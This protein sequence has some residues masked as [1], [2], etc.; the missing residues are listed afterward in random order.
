MDERDGLHVDPAELEGS[1]A[2][3]LI[4]ALVVPR[5]IAWVST[6]SADGVANLAPFSYYAVLS[7]R[8]PTVC[9]SCTGERDTLRN[10]RHTGDF[11]ANVVPESLAHQMNLTAADFPP[12]ESEFAAAGLTPLQSDV[13]KAPRLLESPASLECVV[14]REFAVGAG[15]VV[16]VGRVV[17]IHVVGEVI[18]DGR[19]DVSAFRPVGR[20]AGSGYVYAGE[21]VRLVRPTYA[22]ILSRR[23]PVP[24]DDA[25]VE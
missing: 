12:S 5:P 9:F 15:S 14:E 23:R 1:E 25:P 10:V 20:L 24:S 17:R 6:V 19:V 11:V 3:H 2:Y 13:V 18:R 7:P 21:F 4:N 8:P 16:F 22:D